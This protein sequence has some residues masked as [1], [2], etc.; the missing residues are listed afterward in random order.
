ML[1]ALGIS[2]ATLAGLDLAAIAGWYTFS[3]PRSQW[4]GRA[5]HQG[6]GSQKV[7]ALTFDDGPHPEFTPAVLDILL[8]ERV[9][10]TFF[11]CGHD[12]EIHPDLARRIVDEGHA[13]GNHTYSHPYLYFQSRE[14]IH[15]ELDQ[16]QQAIRRATGRNCR[17]FRPPYGARWVG[18]YPELQARQM[19]LITWSCW[20]E[21][22]STADAVVKD[23]IR[24]LRPG[25]VYLLHDGVQTPGGY[26]AGKSMR[27]QNLEPSEHRVRRMIEAL[28]S[29]ISKIRAEGYEFVDVAQMF[30]IE[31]FTAE[32]PPRVRGA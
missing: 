8:R 7:T 32:E 15:R 23:A 13:V 12:I 2:L 25:A 4:L 19:D 29:L 21:M 5:L 3:W 10:A 14:E 11:L 9:R 6:K 1:N 24:H 20:P 28:P 31:A 27:P 26:F 18:L 17:F 16:T 22:Q 30:G